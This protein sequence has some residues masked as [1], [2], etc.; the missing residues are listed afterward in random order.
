MLKRKVLLFITLLLV[1]IPTLPIYA[2][3]TESNLANKHY[4]IIIEDDADLLTE[5][6]EQQLKSNLEELSEYGY[7]LFKTTNIANNSTSLR[8]IQNYYYSKLQNKSGVAFYIDMNKRQV[9]ACA[10]GGLDK[11]ITSSKCDTIMDNVYTYARK[12]DYYGCAV[13]TF[14]QMN[15]LL[16]GGK[17]AE[18]MKYYCNAILS[19]MVSL[20]ASFGF[21][22][23]ITGNKRATKKELVN[24]CVI[25]LEHSPI[26]VAKTGS[27]RVYSPVSDSSSS[28]GSSGGGGGG[29]GFSG[30]GG[31]H[32]F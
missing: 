10:T 15:R 8:Y 31:S 32:G 30:S 3:T 2:E 14:S 22:M 28:G 6:Q 24:E 23:I 21:F 29:G 4:E 12:G 19:V 11:I 20:F 1:I 5:V 26:E 27:H 25:S 16:S 9:C 13:E 17:I 18:S 7:V